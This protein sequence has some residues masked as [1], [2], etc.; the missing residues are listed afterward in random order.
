M[1]AIYILIVI[2]SLDGSPAM[3]DMPSKDV[4]EKAA[5]KVNAVKLNGFGA[6]PTALCVPASAGE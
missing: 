6:H 3:H 2:V 1:N 5:A 4:C